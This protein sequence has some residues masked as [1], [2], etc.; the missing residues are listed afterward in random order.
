MKMTDAQIENWRKVLYRMFGPVALLCP[1][2]Q[3][4][5]YRD[6]LQAEMDNHFCACDPAKHGT[7]R[8]RDDRVTCNKCGKERKPVEQPLARSD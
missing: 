1:A 2:E 3:I 5:A 8:H 7:T 4:Q 6:W